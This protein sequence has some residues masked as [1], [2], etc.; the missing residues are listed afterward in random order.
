MTGEGEHM[1]ALTRSCREW[2]K[3]HDQ[4]EPG[5]PVAC[6]GSIQ[7]VFPDGVAEHVAQLENRFGARRVTSSESQRGGTQ[8]SG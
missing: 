6:T 2:W 7:L 1:N 4:I 8:C 3:L 5:R